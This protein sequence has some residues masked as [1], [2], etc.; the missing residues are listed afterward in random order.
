MPVYQIEVFVHNT[1]DDREPESVQTRL[2]EAKNE[3]RAIAHAVKAHIAC[4]KPTPGE[5]VE[6]GA[7]GVKIEQAEAE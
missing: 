7:A 6:L 4:T 5:L 3:S 2:I 1:M